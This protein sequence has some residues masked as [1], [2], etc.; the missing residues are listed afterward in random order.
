MSAEDFA[1]ELGGEFRRILVKATDTAT[2][3]AINQLLDMK[4]V[5]ENQP[6][7][8]PDTDGGTNTPATEGQQ[9]GTADASAV[10]IPVGEGQ[11]T[12][13][14]TSVPNGARVMPVI[15]LKKYK[16]TILL[17]FSLMMDGI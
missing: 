12:A 1:G 6:G 8:T 5:N 14:D 17:M 11:Q 16:W 9:T 3:R 4:P 2:E 7:E 15:W 10:N 13:Q